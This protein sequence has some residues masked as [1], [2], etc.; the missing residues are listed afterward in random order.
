MQLHSQYLFRGILYFLLRYYNEQTQLAGLFFKKGAETMVKE[1]G[2]TFWKNLKQPAQNN[3][4]SKKENVLPITPIKNK[5]PRKCT[6]C[7]DKDFSH[8]HLII[9]EDSK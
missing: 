9:C 1:H 6:Y 3:S 2:K 4:D 7:L 5:H 8:I